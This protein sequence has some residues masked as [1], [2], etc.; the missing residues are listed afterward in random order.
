MKTQKYLKPAEIAKLTGVS[1]PNV[2]RMMDRHG[3][4]PD[5]QGRYLETQVHSARQSG[6]GMD[7]AKNAAKV[8]R[9][10]GPGWKIDDQENDSPAVLLLKRKI[11]R[12]DIDIKRA[13]LDLDK[14][15]GLVV[16]LETARQW[17][18]GIGNLFNGRMERFAETM[19]AR[20]PNDAELSEEIR[21]AWDEVK[22]ELAE[23]RPE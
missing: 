6:I 23:A 9:A 10:V 5:K 19:A 11:K 7:K 16:E 1:L 4:A 13:Q 8:T 21:R 18:D 14:A 20:R 15:A 12:A 17:Y 2:R 3:Y 22:A